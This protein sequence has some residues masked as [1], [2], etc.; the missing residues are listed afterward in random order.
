MARFIVLAI[1][2][3]MVSCV[4]CSEHDDLDDDRDDDHDHD[5]LN[6]FEFCSARL[7]PGVN[8]T[9]FC[10]PDD[11]SCGVVCK[12]NGVNVTG[13]IVHCDEDK[14]QFYSA[15]AKKCV[16]EDV[17]SCE[18][19]NV[20]EPS[21]QDTTNA[22]D[23]AFFDDFVK[24]TAEVDKQQSTASRPAA[25][26]MRVG[27]NGQYRDS[28]I[29]TV[30]QGE[31]A[32][33][34]PIY[35]ANPPLAR[36]GDPRVPPQSPQNGAVCRTRYLH[37]PEKA[38]WEGAKAICELEGGQLAVITSEADQNRI[39]SRFGKLREFWIGATDIEREGQFRWVNGQGLGFARWLSGQPTRKYPNNEHCVSF[40]YA[41]RDG[42]WGD[43]NC[44]DSRPFLCETMV[45]KPARGRFP[46]GYPG[47]FKGPLRS[48]YH[49]PRNRNHP[50]PK[51]M[52]GQAVRSWS[53]GGGQPYNEWER[54]RTAI[55][56]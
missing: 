49:F 5:D 31:G 39:M 33:D 14:D 11:T 18:T 20:R 3:L 28:R 8:E 41:W 50:G 27:P 4:L 36:H 44:Y 29:Q 12:R 56:N 17:D 48:P 38:D 23:L 54:I 9:H 30:L 22:D 7:A 46:S 45:C 37:H 53:R 42:K 6:A 34:A 25:G 55:H 13:T 21:K 51:G 15:T 43:R 47:A 2:F 52:G 32:D 40:N 24:E 26:E 16:G 1:A 10:H 19:T 35:P